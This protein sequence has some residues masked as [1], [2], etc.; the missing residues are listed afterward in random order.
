MSAGEKMLLVPEDAALDGASAIGAIGDGMAVGIEAEDGW[1]ERARQLKPP[2]EGTAI[3]VPF[4]LTPKDYTI[5]GWRAAYANAVRLNVQL[6]A[7]RD[8][9]IAERDH[10]RADWLNARA[11]L[12]EAMERE[13]RWRTE[14]IEGR[15]ERD[16]L[17]AERDAA[18]ADLDRLRGDEGGADCDC[19]GEVP[20]AGCLDVGALH[21]LRKGYALEARVNNERF[22]E[23]LRLRAERDAALEALARMRVNYGYFEGRACTVCG[24]PARAAYKSELLCSR[25][26]VGRLAERDAAVE[27]N[28]KLR[29]RCDLLEGEV[30]VLKGPDRPVFAEV[31]RLRQALGAVG[32]LCAIVESLRDNMNGDY[33]AFSLMSEG[34]MDEIEKIASSVGVAPEGPLDEIAKIVDPHAGGA[35]C[36]RP[37]CRCHLGG[38]P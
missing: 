12:N 29:F 1:E 8:A 21:A 14:A 15:A 20:G 34:P 2:P 26:A 9:A 37:D 36:G 27:E 38:R 17:R 6:R 10:L 18:V 5:E 4:D 3:V 28:A 19:G 16:R 33:Y 32:K 35:E 30:G 25:C 24:E 31:A 7:E 23:T 13:A 11:E 22:Q